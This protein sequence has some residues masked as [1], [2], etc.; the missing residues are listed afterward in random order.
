MMKN[1]G[2]KEL[3]KISQS[4]RLVSTHKDM[5]KHTSSTPPTLVCTHTYMRTHTYILSLLSVSWLI[6]PSTKQLWS[7]KYMTVDLSL[8]WSPPGKSFFF[9]HFLSHLLVIFALCIGF[10]TVHIT[11]YLV[12]KSF[13]YYRLPHIPCKTFL[14]T[15]P[16]LSFF[17]KMHDCQRDISAYTGSVSYNITTY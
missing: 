16:K 14:L 3:R 7:K 5:G 15:T 9:V 1:K 11:A 4:Q 12:D 10:I 13:V 6:F 17:C 2:K 8:T